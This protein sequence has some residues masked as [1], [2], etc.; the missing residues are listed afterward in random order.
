[1]AINQNIIKKTG[2]MARVKLMKHHNNNSYNNNNSYDKTKIKVKRET[3]EN[4]LL[5]SIVLQRKQKK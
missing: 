2:N 5:M 3:K 1:M 4:G